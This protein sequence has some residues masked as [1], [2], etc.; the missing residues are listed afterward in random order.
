MIRLCVSQQKNT[1]PYVFCQTGQRVYTFE[2]S[3]YYVYHNWRLVSD[4]F[5]NE[6]FA[7][8]LANIGL[9]FLSSKMRDISLLPTFSMRIIKFLRHTDF[10]DEDELDHLSS[11]LEKWEARQDYEKLKER[12]D[13]F[14]KIGEPIKA[15]PLYRQAIA[16]EENEKLLNNLGVALMQTQNYVEA[17]VCF[18]RA[19]N[20]SPACADVS[21]GL[22]E[23]LIRTG[24][25]K[26]A[27]VR[28]DKLR[29]IQDSADYYYLQGLLA[30]AEKRH[31]DCLTYL[32]DACKLNPQSDFFVYE[33][34][35]KLTA[36]RQFESAINFLENS[37]VRDSSFYAHQ[38][39]VYKAAND[40]PSAIKAVKKAIEL[41]NNK[42]PTLHTKLAGLYR[43]DYNLPQAESSVLTA[44]GVDPEN[45]LAKLELAR[46]KKAQGRLRDYQTGLN[47][48]LG[49]FKRKYSSGGYY[50]R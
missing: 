48:V 2:E 19:Y 47:D 43:Q 3:Q 10:F 5:L 31:L 33:V 18:N 20:L 9:S 29:G 30:W 46:I 14:I 45:E 38:A 35:S 37:P 21:F 7:S 24:N 50:A 42:S 26:E 44:L 25:T 15:I 12:A 32:K 16:L 22:V 13:F 28:L 27:R 1:I 34:S 17:V 36:M 23:S 4:E 39:D 8:W 49:G 6:G 11:R 41:S 40:Y